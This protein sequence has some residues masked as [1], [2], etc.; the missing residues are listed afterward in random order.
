VVEAPFLDTSLF[1][2]VALRHAMVAT[3]FIDSAWLTGSWLA[4][5]SACIP[6]IGQLGSDGTFLFGVCT[7]CV[8]LYLSHT[9]LPVSQYSKM[10]RPIHGNERYDCGRETWQRNGEMPLMH[11]AVASAC[12]ESR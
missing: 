2:T 10:H 9:M 4:I 11:P 1:A 6:E 3:R 8:A 7:C 12:D 5:P